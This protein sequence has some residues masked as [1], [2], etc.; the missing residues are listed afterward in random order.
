MIEIHTRFNEQPFPNKWCQKLLK[1][2]EFLA[3]RKIHFLCCATTPVFLN[4]FFPFLFLLLSFFFSSFVCFMC[5]TFDYRVS[6][7]LCDDCIVYALDNANGSCNHLTIFWGALYIVS[8]ILL[9]VDLWYM[10]TFDIFLLTYRAINSYNSIFWFFGGKLKNTI[11]TIYIG[12]C[13]FVHFRFVHWHF[14]L[15]Q[16][17]HCYLVHG[18]MVT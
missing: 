12:L 1:F 10:W 18:L 16:I 8:Y 3:T 6:K 2:A 13:H 11:L 17:V 15:S 9:Y 5:M 4:N 14:I 7:K